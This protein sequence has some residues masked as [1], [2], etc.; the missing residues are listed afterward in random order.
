MALPPDLHNHACTISLSH[1]RSRTLIT[2]TFWWHYDQGS[3]PDLQVFIIGIVEKQCCIP[4]TSI[5][6]ASQS[7]SVDFVVWH[8][9][10]ILTQH[11]PKAIPVPDSDPDVVQVPCGNICWVIAGVTLHPPQLKTCAWIC[12]DGCVLPTEILPHCHRLH[13]VKEVKQKRWCVSCC[14][15]FN[16]TS[17]TFLH[18]NNAPK[19]FI[20][21]I[22]IITI[23][24]KTRPKGRGIETDGLPSSAILHF[25]TDSL[26]KIG[27]WVA[28]K[29]ESEF[30]LP[31]L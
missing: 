6:N 2:R 16:W 26:I 18:P 15:S 17:A 25:E 24:P 10:K 19:I 14:I 21:T 30:Y 7:Y 8:E 11:C 31:V 28:A 29:A 9:I 3:S 13:G 22:F 5:S 1:S 20:T 12:E 23:I 4:T 27:W